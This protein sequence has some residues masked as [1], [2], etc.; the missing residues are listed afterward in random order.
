MIPSTIQKQGI[1]NKLLE[2]VIKILLTK[3]CNKIGKIKIDINSCTKKIV[4]GEIDK[5]N[6]FAKDI[7]YKDL[8][9][10]ELE[11]EANNLKINFQIIKKKLYFKND[12]II[13]FKIS[14]SHNSLKAVLFSNNWTW[15]KNMLSEDILNLEKLEG[16]KIK[17]DKLFIYTSV[18]KKNF[19][20]SPQIEI[21]TYKGKIFL[22]NS[23]LNKTV[24]IPI[25]E[26]IY[27]EKVNIINNLINIF[28]NSS[29]SF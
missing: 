4:K 13:K 19:I 15:I 25:E 24:Q 14:L 5:I 6:I 8:L 17:N 10:D 18:E 16:I 1:L 12:P 26:K 11:L 22:K 23:N 20:N 7:D 2:Q 28:G 3:E 21:K 9:F 27:I 29:I